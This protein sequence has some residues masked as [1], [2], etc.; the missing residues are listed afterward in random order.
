M[1][2]THPNANPANPETGA[3]FR[4]RNTNVAINRRI[5]R[6]PGVLPGDQRTIPG[7]GCSEQSYF[8]IA[9]RQVPPISGKQRWNIFET[10]F[11]RNIN[12]DEDEEDLD[13][14]LRAY[15]THPGSHLNYADSN[16]YVHEPAIIPVS[17]GLGLG[18]DLRPDLS[19]AYDQLA[20]GSC[21]SHA[22]AGA[23][24][25]VIRKTGQPDFTPSRLFIWYYARKNSGYRKG[26]YKA[27]DFNTGTS[28]EDALRVLS[29]GVCSEDLWPYVFNESNN[30]GIYKFPPNS[31]AATE[32]N[33]N[34]RR[35]AR[36]NTAT[37][38]PFNT[39]KSHNNLIDCLDSGYPFIFSMNV[40]DWL[41][42]E[43]LNEHNGYQMQVPIN[44][45]SD[46]YVNDGH[47]FLTVGYKPQDKTFII[48][49]SWGPNWG[50]H[51]HFYMA[52]LY[53][54]TYSKEFWIVR[55]IKK[56]S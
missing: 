30:R 54:S 29:S 28:V 40:R 22:V 46:K 5:R 20:M 7:S 55:H 45:K 18:V 6:A 56:P 44:P 24:E 16:N 49:N 41:D 42:K 33:Q 47:V 23:L 1:C 26:H 36:Q 10:R 15:P 27:T 52:Y 8:Q 3:T 19:E 48:R 4:T 13:D 17:P 14:K 31:K 9:N 43:N 11:E 32:P 37:F 2:K 38:E 35:L 12:Q 21:A 39:E 25:F 50:D 34:S 53:M 51:G